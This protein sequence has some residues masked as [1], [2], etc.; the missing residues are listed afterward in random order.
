MSATPTRRAAVLG[1]ALTLLAV[2]CTEQFA[3]K[4][5]LQSFVV[6][7]TT[8]DPAQKLGSPAAPLGFISGQSCAATACENGETCVDGRCSRCFTIDARS[9]GKDGEAFPYS[10]MLHVDVTPGFVSPSTEYFE[11]KDGASKN[12]QVCLNRTSGATNIWVEHDGVV[13]KASGVQYGQCNDGADNDNNGLI[14]LADPGCKGVGDDLEGAVTLSTGL[15][16]TMRFDTPRIR[17]LQRTELIRTSPMVDEE[18]L[19]DQGANVVTGVVGAGFYA[20]D[21]GASPGDG[22]PFNSIFVFTFSAPKG[23]K[24]GD[25]VCSFA[26]GVQEH[27]GHSQV[28][29]PSYETLYEKKLNPDLSRN[30]KHPVEA[31]EDCGRTLDAIR[32]LFKDLNQ[33]LLDLQPELEALEKDLKAQVAAETDPDTKKTLETALAQATEQIQLTKR[34]REKS[35]PVRQRMDKLLADAAEYNKGVAPALLHSAFNLVRANASDAAAFQADM[36]DLLVKTEE[37]MADHNTWPQGILNRIGLR[38]DV[39]DDLK[40]ETGAFAIIGENSELLEG[41][42]SDLTTIRNIQVPTRLIACD[43]DKNGI[44]EDGDENTCRNDCQ[45]DELC[46]DLEGFFEHRQWSGMVDG[47]KVMGVSVALAARFTPL[48]ID[49]LGEEDQQTLCQ[50]TETPLGFLEYTCPPRKLESVTGS[51]RHVYLCNRSTGSNSC[52]L[53]FWILDPRFDGD[54]VLP[55]GLD[56]DGDGFTPEKGDCND[57]NPAVNPNASEILGNGEDDDCDGEES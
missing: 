27:V 35:T 32:K 4:N 24:L 37:I 46:T 1:A 28:I 22:P 3:L 38:R 49:F 11:M 47:R 9:L 55:A 50:K 36:A 17:Q 23:I 18:V 45:I 53:Q 7:F 12:I 5:D 52:G 10:G 13:P 16:P 43:R 14:D 42:E 8:T 6:T 54:V 29:F 26:G 34:L 20:T 19:V 25:V 15:S 21:F 33:P 48:K 40:V 30:R 41:Y 51:V 39:T 2:G 31:F 56:Q 57:N 44:I